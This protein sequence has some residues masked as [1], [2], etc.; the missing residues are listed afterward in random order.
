MFRSTTS[1]LALLAAMT[2]PAVA[3]D[4]GDWG[5]D[6]S[7][8]P[9]FRT[10]YP[11]E[12]GDWAGLGDDDDPISMEIGV[13]YWYSMGYL[14]LSNVA[15]SF[16]AQD[17]A[18]SGEL[19]L[20]ISDHSTNTFAKAIAG[21][22][23]SMGGSYT[24]PFGAGTV[25]DGRL[26]Y[27]EADIGYHAFGNDDAGVGP[28]VGYLYWNNSP[29]TDRSNFSPAESSADVGYDQNTGQT[30]LPMDS[31]DNN[32]DI[33]ALRL[34]VQG[35]ADFGMFDIS[36]EVAAVPYAKVSGTIGNDQTTTVIDHSV[37]APGNVA[38]IKASET[39][40]DGW[41]YGAMAEAFVGMHPTEN[42]TVRL[43]GR[44]WYL[45]GT[46]DMTYDQAFIGNPSDSDAV[47]PPNFDTPP[48]FSK[49][50]FIETANPFSM[51]RL[52]VL[53]ELTYR[54]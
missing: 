39:T 42:V 25:T 36:G 22:A 13:R 32:L 7:D 37:Y 31:E 48:S 19:H 15:G 43:G 24:D 34:G 9:D 52:G 6:F 21:Y 47:N 44:A 17:T 8:T 41:G 23:F 26:G 11:V 33:H 49:T 40:L 12:P 3:A 10:S 2:V 35:R 30:F 20:R 5:D 45:Q 18:H 14:S 38:S 16:E 29:R 53:A 27:I 1:I 51:L 54:F 50:T 4:Y 46:A 28:L